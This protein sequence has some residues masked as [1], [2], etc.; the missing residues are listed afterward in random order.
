M[1]NVAD[2]L[3]R[4]LVSISKLNL[5]P[6]NARKHDERN[7]CTIKA[8]LQR[9]GQLKPIV[10][11]REGMLIRAGNGTVQAAQELGWKRIAAIV[12]DMTN[13]EAT[14]FALADNRSSELGQWNVDAL[15][16]LLSDWKEDEV[17]AIGFD[18][19]ELEALLSAE[20][21]G[22]GGW[23]GAQEV[24]EDEVPE[25]P[26]E[27]T[28]KRGQLWALG[29]H[30]VLCGDS[31][32]TAPFEVPE[33]LFTD[34]P[35]GVGYEA[36]RGGAPIA[37]DGDLA[38]AEAVTKAALK[39]ALK[40][41]FKAG[42]VC[43]DWRS[44]GWVVAML[45]GLNLKPK[46]CI[47]WDKTRGVQNL[48]RYHKQHEMLVYFG[49]YGGEETRCGDVWS[50]P[51]DFDPAHPTPK[52]VELAAKAIETAGMQTVY[53]PFLGS[54]TTLI[55][56]EQ[57]GRTCYGIEIEPRYVDVIIQRWEN[58]TGETAELIE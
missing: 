15:N 30:R 7:I 56:A 47:V 23:A 22:S 41:A 57:L 6:D 26:A 16:R 45:D 39:A 27:P 4:H 52:P 29:R 55:A 44:M 11:Q 25:A 35:Y 20:N 17:A 9:F 8:S 2:P 42:F 40:G 34:P 19:D 50:I 36:M 32:E 24:V 58:L 43:S 49:P 51:R 21:D 53:D 31:T 12:V 28:A 33:F 3:T 14:A 1:K 46:A 37:N 38:T 54:G 18:P 13:E 48:D 5:D 10:V